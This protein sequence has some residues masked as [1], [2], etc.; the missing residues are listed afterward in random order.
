MRALVVVER[1][2]ALQALFQLWYCGI[3][4]QVDV[5]VLEGAPEPIGLS[6]AHIGSLSRF[7]W[8]LWRKLFPVTAERV[9]RAPFGGPREAASR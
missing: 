8:V 9:R 3:L 2:V 7:R 5:F 6:P 4:V 1:E